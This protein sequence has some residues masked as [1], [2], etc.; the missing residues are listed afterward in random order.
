MRRTVSNRTAAALLSDSETAFDSESSVSSNASNSS[1]RRNRKN[2]SEAEEACLISGVGK[3]KITSLYAN[4]SLFFDCSMA[5]TGK[6]S[7]MILNT[8]SMVVKL[9]ICAS[10]KPITIDFL[11]HDVVLFYYINTRYRS[12][13]KSETIASTPDR[14]NMIIFDIRSVNEKVNEVFIGY[15]WSSAQWMSP[16]NIAN[17]EVLLADF[18]KKIA[19]KQKMI[20]RISPARTPSRF[21][22]S[23]AINS[24]VKRTKNSE[25]SPSQDDENEGT[26]LKKTKHQTQSSPLSSRSVK[27]NKST[28]STNLN[29][30]EGILI[31]SDIENDSEG[32]VYPHEDGEP[33]PEPQSMMGRC[34]I[35]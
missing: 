33:T 16:E 20:N 24:A 12:L 23:L 17:F 4:F 19:A 14:A 11:S 15:D 6:K 30:Q 31:H 25:E 35:M 28:K 2:W 13:I 3:V 5:R 32:I 27:S 21:I 10:S 34:I 26:P 7:S 9:R 22:S 18:E 8:L 29:T 1:S